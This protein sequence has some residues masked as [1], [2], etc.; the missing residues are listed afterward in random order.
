MKYKNN[1]FDDGE[2]K[3]I[4]E[5]GEERNKCCDSDPK[6]EVG[7]IENDSKYFAKRGAYFRVLGSD[8]ASKI[9]V[10]YAGSPTFI[11]PTLYKG[12]RKMQKDVGLDFIDC[13]AEMS[14][15]LDGTHY[16]DEGQK[17]EA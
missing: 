13:L 17:I 6:G 5:I 2:E 4:I 8:S 1:N 11:L 12:L 10:A 7:Y 14:D 15:V 3:L 9:E 16:K